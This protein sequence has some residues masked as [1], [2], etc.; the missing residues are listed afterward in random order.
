MFPFWGHWK[1][2]YLLPNASEPWSLRVRL[3]QTLSTKTWSATISIHSCDPM[4]ERGDF[5]LRLSGTP[6]AGMRSGAYFSLVLRPPIYLVFL[7]RDPHQQLILLLS[8]SLSFPSCSW[9]K[10]KSRIGFSI[11]WH[12]FSNLIVHSIKL[13]LLFLSKLPLQ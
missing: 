10:F 12:F 9:L 8:T 7:C 6:N 2:S 4:L 1:F 11:I 13:M 5:S 3:S